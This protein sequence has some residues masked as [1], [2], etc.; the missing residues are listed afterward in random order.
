MCQPVVARHGAKAIPT[1]CPAGGGT[2]EMER[3][4]FGL[5]GRSICVSG[6]RMGEP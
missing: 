1:L 5:K 3:L 2:S 4:E 6:T